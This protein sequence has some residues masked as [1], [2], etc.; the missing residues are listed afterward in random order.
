MAERD[1]RYF[2]QLDYLDGPS[3]AVLV[4][5]S[6]DAAVTD[7]VEAALGSIRFD[8]PSY[9]GDT[10]VL[11]IDEPLPSM[12]RSRLSCRGDF[13]SADRSSTRLGSDA[14]ETRLAV[15]PADDLPADFRHFTVTLAVEGFSASRGLGVEIA[16]A[17]RRGP[18]PAA[19]ADRIAESLAHVASRAEPDSVCALAR[20]ALGQGGDDTEAMLGAG[21]GPIEDCH[22]CADFILVP[23]LWCRLRYR[24]TA[25]CRPS[26]ANRCRRARLPLLDG[27]AR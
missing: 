14:G 23:L 20:L 15:A 27:R 19:L 22:D 8:R 7:A 26:L 10:P 21:L 24:R 17:A 11:V 16:H 13:I 2:I 9:D 3:A 25:V 12:P 6:A 1:A 5:G 18:A 4:G